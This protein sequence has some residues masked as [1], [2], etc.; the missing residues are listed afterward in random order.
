MALL[1]YYGDT[2]K[3]E[4]VKSNAGDIVMVLLRRKNI[5]V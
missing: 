1:T 5:F 2:G 3:F 4:E